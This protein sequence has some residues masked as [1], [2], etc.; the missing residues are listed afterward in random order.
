MTADNDYNLPT[1]IA[2]RQWQRECIDQFLA[3]TLSSS[4]YQQA[5]TFLSVACPGSGKTIFML[6]LACHLKSRG[7]VDWVTICV[8]SA[9]LRFQVALTAKLFGLDLDHGEYREKLSELPSGFH[10]DIVTYQAVCSNSEV[11]RARC[12]IKK[13]FLIADEVHHLG[14]EKAWGQAFRNAF[15][16][17]RYR[18]LTSGTP[19]RSDNEPIP[20]VNYDLMRDADGNPIKDRCGKSQMISRA[21][22]NYGYGEALRDGVCRQ[23]VFPSYEGRFEWLDG[24]T[25]YEK[26]FSD[27]VPQSQVSKRR[28]TCLLADGDWVGKVVVDANNKLSQL[29]K[30]FGGTCHKDAGGLIVCIDKAHACEVA[31][32]LERKTGEKPVV[33]TSDDPQASEKIKAFSQS[34]SRWIVAVK[35][36]SEGIDIPRLRVAVF[37]TNV[38]TPMYFRQIMG[39]IT[40]MMGLYDDETAYMYIYDDDELVGLAKQVRDER[41]HVI[42][43]QDDDDL[44]TQDDDEPS[45]DGQRSL[46][47]FLPISSCGSESQHLWNGESYDSKELEYARPHALDLG[48]PEAKVVELLRRIGS[49]PVATVD[50]PSLD[51]EDQGMTKTELLMHLRRK[52]GKLTSQLAFILTPQGDPQFDVIHQTWI[53]SYPGSRGQASAGERELRAKI[54]WLK[55]CIAQAAL[56]FVPSFLEGLNG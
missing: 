15:D 39:R 28:R 41:N 48:I 52:A 21:D 40:R 56:V 23:V 12:S 53:K 30:G 38:M 16:G 51:Q 24:T 14:T 35:M 54:E 17:A 45:E 10:G 49:A 20:Y 47:I 34:D 2:L 46:G 9:H 13:M 31:R 27:E 19:F 22:Y 11:W 55:A 32:T 36:V 7:V 33:V 50:R 4:V 26:S 25:V 44:P 29:R 5:N 3:K 6:A 37:C 43:E 18:L 42:A 8:P 1:G